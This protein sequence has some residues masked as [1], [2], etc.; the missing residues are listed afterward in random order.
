[1]R[2]VVQRDLTL[3]YD[4]DSGYLGYEVKTGTEL[5]QVTPFDKILIIRRGADYFVT[6]A[7]EKLFVDKGMLACIMADKELLTNTVFSVVYLDSTN[8]CAYLKRCRI[9]QCYHGKNL[10]PHTRWLLCMCP[11]YRR[12]REDHSPLCS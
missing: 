10:S 2:E 3:R 5:F 11:D 9:E 6:K 12:E 7:P 1:V 4:A 8:G